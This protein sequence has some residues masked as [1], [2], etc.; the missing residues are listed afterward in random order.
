M[1]ICEG[2]IHFNEYLVGSSLGNIYTCKSVRESVA[3]SS[4]SNSRGVAGSEFCQQAAAWDRRKGC[5]LHREG[6]VYYIGRGVYTT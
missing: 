4:F 5:I 2:S 6:G 1:E 3:L